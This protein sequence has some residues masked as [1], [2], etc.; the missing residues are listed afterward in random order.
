MDGDGVVDLDRSRIYFH[1][2]SAG[3]IY[4][5]VFAAISLDVAAAVFDSGG[6]PRMDIFRWNRTA[7]P[8]GGRRPSLLNK[9]ASSD[10]DYVLSYRPMEIIDVPGALTIQEYFERGEWVEMPGDPFAYAPHLWSSTLPGVPMKRV[11]FQFP[12][13]DWVLPNPTETALVRAAN[14]REATSFYRHDLAMKLFPKLNPVGHYNSIPDISLFGLKTEPLP[15]CLI[16]MLVQEQAAGFLASH[17]TLIPDVN[18][19]PQMWFRVDL[20]E[21]PPKSLTEDL[22]R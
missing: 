5:P 4:G 15:Q 9:G 6:V 7:G 14:L 1:G 10:D 18:F 21:M 13:G 8:V 17:G 20:F 22:K 3:G 12:K 2:L 11:L 16:A 19:W